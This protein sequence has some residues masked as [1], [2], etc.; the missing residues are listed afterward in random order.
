MR[1]EKRVFGTDSSTW[2][3]RPGKSA[4]RAATSTGACRTESRQGFPLGLVL[5][6]AGLS[7]V[8]SIC[9]IVAFS[10]SFWWFLPL[11]SVVGSIG[12]LVGAA[13][14]TVARDRG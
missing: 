2:I 3:E 6:A 11:Y 7:A 4:P 8:I 12:V 14:G 1:Q 5:A 13:V 10:L 9:L